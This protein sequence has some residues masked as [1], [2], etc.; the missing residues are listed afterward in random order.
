MSSARIAHDAAWVIS[1]K[2]VEI[3]APCLREEER[4]DAFREFYAVVK[5]GT[6]AALIHY[7]REVSRLHPSRN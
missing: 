4:Q 7:A 2:L 3:I 5:A 6:E 1:M